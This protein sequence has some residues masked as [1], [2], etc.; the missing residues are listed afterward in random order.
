MADSFGEMNRRGE[1]GGRLAVVTGG[2]SGIG[3]ELA[4]CAAKDGYEL[5]IAADT[6][7][8]QAKA[9]LSALGVQVTGITADLATKDGV[10]SLMDA[11]GGRD[12]DLLFANAGHGLGHG[13]LDQDF[14]EIQHLID[15]NITGTLDV[16][17]RVGRRMRDRNQG[18]I[19]I[20]GSIAG[21]MPGTF[22]AVYNGSKA[23]VDSFAF[24]LRNELKDSKV[25][26]SLLMPGPT[27]TEFFERA[28]LSDTKV[29][30]SD[31]KQDPAEV[32]ESGYKAMMKGEDHVVAGWKNKL[33]AYIAQVTPSTTL[34][35]MHRG[36]AEP[37]K[38]KA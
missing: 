20:T 10:D 17:Q 11:I 24:A 5:I 22:Q 19:L 12:V 16:I 32:A 6:D 34:A 30:Q 1:G 36:M 37:E 13:F 25:T 23:F 31:S 8:D 9:E 3:L 18:R 26:V 35:E 33:Q 29:G 28:N 15:T 2:S 4:K 7:V 27:D 14:T 21:V 38:A